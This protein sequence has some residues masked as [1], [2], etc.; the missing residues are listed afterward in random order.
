MFRSLIP[1]SPFS[2]TAKND[3]AAI[4]AKFKVIYETEWTWRTSQRIEEEEDED[5]GAGHLPI[6]DEESQ[7]ARLKYWEDVMGQLEA[8]NPK[9]LSKPQQLNYGVYKAQIEVLLNNQRF[10]DYQ[11]PLNADSSFWA[12]LAGISGT[13]LSTTSEYENYISQLLE[14]PRYFDGQIANMRAGYKRGFTPPRITL[15][16]RD[17]S[18]ASIAEVSNTKDSAFYKPFIIMP[19]HIDATQQADLRARCLD[20]IN[21]SVLP[22]YRSL[23]TFFR[24][25]YYPNTRKTLAGED[26]PNGKAY[27]QAKNKEFT[28]LDLTPSEIHQIGLDEIARIRS[29][30][31]ITKAEAK[32]DG[33]LPAFIHFLRTDPQFYAK[34]PEQLLKEAAWI[35]KQFDGVSSKFFGRLPRQRFAIIPVPDDIA[36]FYTSGRGGPGVYLVNT[37]DLPSRALYSLPALTLHESAPGHAFQMPLVLEHKDLPPFRMKYISAFGEGWALYCEYL[38]TEMG[39]YHTPYDTFGMLSYQA[40]RAARL[41]VDTGIHSFGWTREQAQDYLRDKTAL[42]THEVETEVDRYIAW[43]GQALS[44]YLGELAIL[45]ARRKAEKALGE[46]FDIRAFH[47]AVLETGSIPLNLLE[48]HIDEFIAGGGVGPYWD[49]VL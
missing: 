35:A 26:L 20:A 11:K 16:G 46:R 44:Y 14:T 18:I 49:D 22:S 7:Q 48:Q 10:K 19:S 23:L 13:T 31:M 15:E 33:D 39:I 36:P 28:T 40:W 43:P 41:V 2:R 29:E 5:K 25:E 38:G 24:Q 6:V 47:D 3:T 12:S 4:D 21:H 45:K 34:T 27:V 42:S 37:Y 8:I 30:M 32:F 1:S 9:H 17:Q